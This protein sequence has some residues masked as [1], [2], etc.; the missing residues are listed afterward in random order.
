[1]L[2]FTNIVRVETIQESGKLRTEYLNL[3]HV[4][5]LYTEDEN[6]IVELTNNVKLKLTTS[7][8]DLVCEQFFIGK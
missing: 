3:A 7:N 2:K 5:R 8:I 4:L 1:M 6:V